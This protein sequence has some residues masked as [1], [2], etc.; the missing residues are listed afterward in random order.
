VPNNQYQP[1]TPYNASTNNDPYLCRYQGEEHLNLSSNNNDSG[2]DN[3]FQSK[4]NNV[5]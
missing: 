4:K 1:P 2:N 5:N 3:Y